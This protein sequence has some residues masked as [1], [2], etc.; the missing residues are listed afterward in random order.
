M[1][2]RAII[3]AA[4]ALNPQLVIADE[5][6]SM[7]DAAVIQRVRVG[8]ACGPPPAYVLTA[9]TAELAYVREKQIGR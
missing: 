4:V 9:L 5:P 6:I 3:A 1:K 7:L 8:G 2:Q